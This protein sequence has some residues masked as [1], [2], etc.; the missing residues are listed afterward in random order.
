MGL[1]KWLDERT[2]KLGIWDIKLM[3]G[4]MICIAFIVAKIIPQVLG[5]DLVWY[6]VIFVILMVRPYYAFLIKK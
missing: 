2:K 5:L 1:F 3:A 4:G 6:I